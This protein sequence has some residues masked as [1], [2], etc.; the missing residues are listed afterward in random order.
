MGIA[1]ALEC[2]R[3]GAYV[4]LVIG[5]TPEKIPEG[6]KIIKVTSAM[7]M[8]E[9]CVPLFS[10]IDIAIMC[11]AVA[12][13]MPV[14]TAGEKI[15]K[16]E[17]LL[18][19]E[20]KRTPDILKKLGELKTVSQFLVGF[21]LET[22]QGKENALKKL[23]SKNADMIVLNSLNDAGA[24]FGHD[25]NKISIFDR[26]GKEYHFDTKS[27]DMVATDIINTIIKFNE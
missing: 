17:D 10:N 7:E 20:F 3:R 25:T 5:P 9:S 27:K 4:T 26:K 15:K 11:A 6:V 16:T 1:L 14:T 12:D 13:Y 21:A 2:L 19:I 23:E 8:F 18:T 24:G 22:N